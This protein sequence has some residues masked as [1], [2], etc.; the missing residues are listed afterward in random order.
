M[1]RGVRFERIFAYGKI[2]VRA[3]NVT[4]TRFVRHTR[5]SSR[6]LAGS[7][8]ALLLAAHPVMAQTY[9]PTNS[10]TDQWSA[11]TNWTATPVSGLDTS[12]IF[13]PLAFPDAAT[14]TNTNTNDI[15]AFT[16][17]ALTL[18]GAGPLTAGFPIAVTI[19]GGT[20][21][22]VNSSTAVGP[23]I[24]LDA[25]NGAGAGSTVSYIVNSNIALGNALTLTGNG[26]GTFAFNGVISGAN[27]I[28]KSGTS[29]ITLGGVNTY[30]GATTISAGTVRISSAAGLGDGSATNV[31]NLGAGSVLNVT[32][33]TF[34]LGAPRTITMT[35][36]STLQVD[37]GAALTVSGAIN[38]G[39]NTLTTA[40]TGAGGTINLNGV[41]SGGGGLTKNNNGT[42]TL[43]GANTYSGATTVAGGTLNI[44][45]ANNLGDGSVTNNIIL[46]GNST[47]NSTGGVYSLGANRSI[48]M[49]TGAN[50]RSAAGTLT[51]DGAINTGA[52]TLN[53]GGLGNIVLNGAI[54]GTAV[55]AVTTFN[56]GVGNTGKVTLGGNN[57][58]T[59]NV[60]ATANSTLVL[61]SDTALGTGSAGRLVLSGGAI[62]ALGA[63]TFGI[64][65]NVVIGTATT[66]GGTD[67][68]TF[69]GQFSTTAGQTLTV[70]NSLTTF[71]L[72]PVRD[73]GT[74][75]RTLTF[76]GT[77]NILIN[78]NVT[79]GSTGAN[80]DIDYTGN[81]TLTFRGVTNSLT[82]GQG[83][84]YKGAGLGV[85]N[86]GTV[87]YD[88]TAAVGPA[89]STFTTGNNIAVGTATTNAKLK[90]KGNYNVTFNVANKA[91][92]FRGGDSTSTGRGNLDLQDGT[93]NTLVIDSL[94]TAAQNTLQLA[95]GGAATSVLSMD[96]G[97]GGTDKIQINTGRLRVESG[98][99]IISLNGIGGVVGGT[100]D[101]IQGFNLASYGAV[102]TAF[103]MGATTGNF[104]G[105]T[106][107][108]LGWNA[109]SNGLTVTLGGLV[110]DPT[111]AYW[112]GGYNGIW[113]HFQ[114]GLTNNTNWRSDQGGTIDTHQMPG[115]GVTD[116][117]FAADT[118]GTLTTTLGQD[119]SINSLTFGD[120]VGAVSIGGAN[121]LTVGAG[122][123]NA[124]ATAAT[125]TI[126]SA[127]ALGAS[128]TW[129][130]DNSTLNV[131]G[132]ISGGGA[133]T[134]TKTGT[135]TLALGGVNTFA[136]GVNINDGIV[137]T[138]N[139]G[140]LSSANAVTFGASAPSTAGL[141]LNGHNVTIGALST[142]ATPGTP[143]IENANATGGVLTV[144]QASNTTF[145]GV[146]R[147]GTG[148]GTLGLTKTGAGTLT[149]GGA[150][151]YTGATTVT[152]GRL[153]VN[154]SLGST[155]V[156]VNTSNSV[157]GG[158]G[159]IGGLTT[160]SGG[161]KVTGGDIGTIG[162]LT[163]TNGLTFNSNGIGYFDIVNG[164]ASDLFNI[165]GGAFSL[166]SGAILRVTSGLTTPGTYNLATYVGADPT[167]GGIVFQDLTGNSL[168]SNYSFDASGGVL[169]L[170]ISAGTQASPGISLALDVGSRV[171]HNTAIGVSG[172]VTNSG[173]VALNGALSSTGQLAV[174][175]LNPSN[176][177]VPANGG[178]VAYTGSSNSGS[179][180]GDRTVAV[181]V[182]D[183]AASPT[184]ASD[185]KTVSVLQDRVIAASTVAD[186]GLK[187][188]GATVSGTTNLTSTGLDNENTRVTVGNGTDGV[189]S[190][191][192]STSTV[193]DG[194]TS[195]SR[196][197]SGTLNNLGTI[198]GHITLTPGT[199][200]GI[201]GTQTPVPIDVHYTAQVY[202]GKAQW[203]NSGATGSWLNSGQTNWKDTLG[204]GGPGAPG[205]DGAL[206]A[207]DTATFAD[208]AGAGPAISITLD[209]QSPSLA[210]MNFTST[211]TS[212]TIATGTGTGKITLQGAATPVAVSGTHTISAV[213]QGGGLTKTGTGTLIISGANTYTGA[214]TIGNGIMQITGGNDRLPVAS[215][216]VLGSGTDSGKLILGDVSSARTQIV[217]G[218]ATAGT[219]TA[220]SIVG[221]NAF[222]S[223][224]TV[225][226]NPATA[227]STTFSGTIGGAGTNEN[228]LTLVKTGNNGTLILTGNNTYTGGTTL[229]S[230]TIQLGSAGALGNALVPGTTRD[231]TFGGGTLQLSAATAGSDLWS[232][233]FTTTGN[234]AYRIDT[235]GQDFTLANPLIASGTSG[236]TKSGA[237]TL[238]MASGNTY[239]GLTTVAGGALKTQADLQNEILGGLKGIAL[240][241]GVW[242][243]NLSGDTLVQGILN[244]GVGIASW[245]S[246]GLSGQSSVPGS[247]M[248][249]TLLEADG[250]TTANLVWNGAAADTFAYQRIGAAGAAPLIFGSSQANS[251]IVM[252]N[253]INLNTTDHFSK[254]IQVDKGVGGDSAEL[255]G[256]IS[257]AFVG[258]AG[259]AGSA[260]G[261]NKTG[262]GTLILS[263]SGNSYTGETTI[264][265]GTLVAMG[266][267]PVGAVGATGVFGTGSGAT[268]T[269]AVTYYDILMGGNATAV[270]TPT[271]MIGGA[272]S[273]DR[274][275]LIQNVA[276]ANY[277]IG[278]NS[279]AT[280]AYTATIS[281][282]GRNFTVRQSTGGTLNLTGANATGLNAGVSITG[283]NATPVTA[284][285]AGGGSIN[286]SGNIR[287]SLVAGGVVSVVKS[288][289]GTTTFS[290]AK[291]YTGTTTVSGGVLLI[292]SSSTIAST[293]AITVT[294]GQFNYVGAAALNRNVTVGGT[295]EFKYNNAGAFTGSL[296]Y[297]PGG[298]ISGS[299]N[300]ANTALVFAN[301]TTLSPGNSPGNL[302][303]GDGTTYG[304]G[305]IYL[306]EITDLSGPAGTTWDLNTITGNLNLT[307]TTLN[308]FTI[309]IDSLNTLTG[310]NELTPYS[311]KIATAASITG[312]DANTYAFDTSAFDM[313][314]NNPYGYFFMSVAGSDL[315]LNY[316]VPEPSTYAMVLGGL[317]LLVW[318]RRRA[319][320]K[321]EA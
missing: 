316:A 260:S 135:G 143:F 37:A 69:N 282:T 140:A 287:D 261:L 73:T 59:G 19:N 163:F 156:A 247:T 112:K 321:T 9:T 183:P 150:N 155:A 56:G 315:M 103:S 22:F 20:L 65:N 272:Y 55:N 181:T 250:A 27:G 200:A 123:I 202:S 31:I 198:D 232:N 81:G 82:A 311:W 166:N 257:G 172:N 289:S 303:S 76:A 238:V 48:T 134:L 117:I 85:S 223:I 137:R 302:V 294:A 174:N 167:L 124:H 259:S 184:S 318:V 57:T 255:S 170:T 113:N 246:G 114:D 205:L 251:K 153:L 130:V 214:T 296:T 28:T 51:V 96:V 317:A 129:Q 201:Q 209:G 121:T 297:S 52:N 234:N 16:L 249:V 280:S 285:F 95:A 40:S 1:P 54:S 177:N 15:G 300:F 298:I 149:L 213:M 295:G 270:N 264:S 36:A 12:L 66:I 139:N 265:G 67:S 2:E 89:V 222:N 41:I 199:E 47:L 291:S 80:S 216:L 115:H 235:N 5:A 252:T 60:T 154:G 218:I 312:F 307:S 224:L 90:I 288:G 10:T 310:W 241:G 97:G 281:S 49:T 269:P 227:G 306:W 18:Q 158:T 86:F 253:N 225:A 34:D 64:G 13:G 72:V 220:N 35:G 88:G 304:Q 70:N 92:T 93:R 23:V 122:G 159:S 185:S 271:L 267:V 195:D 194:S 244:G 79:D 189:L 208:V 24:H 109:T 104:N 106:T 203:N 98:G 314:M 171:M 219:G 100:F 164:G 284:T 237:G 263:N 230:G 141:Q 242:Q 258:A 43:G 83:N 102:A 17:N 91:L 14:V 190:T 187:H 239:T 299:G 274:N 313:P 46:T 105:Y 248:T 228:N 133:N 32:A 148:G 146:L 147:N 58:F 210:G 286:V 74:G 308:K 229:T 77:G 118:P 212:Y 45:A 215:A 26:S 309:K 243:L 44:S 151:T 162:T 110:A 128:Q 61:A 275:V 87:V 111:T 301:G 25:A 206:S 268:A 120:N 3:M 231:I 262:E 62:E 233:R 319:V 221:G 283:V 94:N 207:G 182:T 33:G 157:L 119:V 6:L 71:G 197:V 240:T 192:G 180:L 236:F 191:S 108:T 68:L 29:A 138:N 75:N 273:I 42:L 21:N 160:I 186:F 132:V 142:N 101:L 116:V 320:R 277:V 293:S 226:Y 11:G 196:T 161:G 266:N 39:G 78:G 173:P 63:R 8:M 30:S 53:V 168:G 245:T 126:T 50:L 152:A 144:S 204:A 254:V 38:N 131:N 145:A 107:A 176:P 278:G 256:I 7:L 179:T 165:T 290:G 136:G 127:V 4:T 99:T 279:T 276:A 125:P 84:D 175:T 169:K 217:G 193:F 188:Q 292:D 211:T 178:S 305:G